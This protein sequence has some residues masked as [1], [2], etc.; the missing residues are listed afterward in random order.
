MDDTGRQDADEL[1][2]Q[3]A[4]LVRSRRPRALW[5]VLAAVG[6]AAGALVVTSAGDDGAA[7]PGL[8]VDLG[9]TAGRAEG[10]AADSMLAWIT[11][12]PG[13]DLPALGGEAAAYRLRGEVSEGQVRALAGALG[14]AGE[15]VHDGPTWT[16]SDDDGTLEV[17]EDGGASWW[18]R[19]TADADAG[20]GSSGATPGTGGGDR[21]AVASDDVVVDCTVPPDPVP[22]PCVATDDGGCTTPACPPGEA[23]TEPVPPDALVDCAVD[24]GGNVVDSCPD[25]SGPPVDLPSDDEARSI[26]LDLLAAAGLD[27]DEAIVTLEGPFDAWYVTVEPRLDGVPSGLL[28]D[29]TIGS[30]GVVIAAGGHLGTAER[31]GDHPRLDTRAAIERANAQQGVAKDGVAQY[32]GAATATGGTTGGDVPVTTIPACKVQPDGRDICE[33][34]PGITCPQA[35]PPRDE[36]V[37]APETLDCTPPPARPVDPMPEPEPLEIVLVDAEPA[38]LLLPA[39]DGSRDAYLVPAY[40]FTDADGGRVDLAAVADESLTAPQTTV[41]EVPETPILPDPGGKPPVDPQPC[42]SPLVAEDDRSTTHTVQPNPDCLDPEAAI[43]VEYY[44]DVLP[45][46]HC[47]WIS[48]EFGGRWWWADGIPTE[49]IMQ[50]SQP[51]EG[52]TLTLLDE[53]HA[54]FVGDAQRTK[55]ATLVPYTGPGGRPLCD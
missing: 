12:V 16:V 20:S 32:Q 23:C 43:G 10:A 40:R 7:R 31:L 21:C 49:E 19:T 35:A 1:T 2:L 13:D 33:I 30:G 11:Y 4:T 51:T 17:V 48:V 22:S 55:V 25:R 42:G 34:E 41:T 52:G 15:V 18:Y 3:P 45:I 24:E 29:V 27:V 54:E 36:P 8:P 6:L 26:A 28:A 44:V 14:V 50:W 37:S 53:G 47:N 9:S 39:N 38:L 46:V 5:A